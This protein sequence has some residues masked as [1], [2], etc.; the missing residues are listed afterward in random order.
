MI[1]LPFILILLFVGPALSSIAI[2][3]SLSIR[4]HL[5]L[6]GICILYGISPFLLAWGG[7][8]LAKRFG[9]QTEAMMFQCP[10]P[11]WHGEIV[12]GMV[13]AHWLAIFTIPS[14][15][16]GAIGLII[17]LRIKVKRSPTTVNISGK[18][19]AAFYRSRRHKV[20]AGVCAAISRRWRLPI[21]GVR[22]V[23]VILAVVGS[24]FVLL[25]YLWFW[26][27]FPLEAQIESNLVA[28]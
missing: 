15:V 24:G 7:M 11:S 12:T 10:N 14:A 19:N 3:R 13:F 23:T 16:F 17:S 25:L 9:C 6:F 4:W 2:R 26:L 1:Y 5:V 20:I 18:P 21:Q 28:H 27:A 8:G 22:I